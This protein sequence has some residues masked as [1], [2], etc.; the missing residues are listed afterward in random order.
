MKIL[1][2][3]EDIAVIVKPYGVSSQTS[4]GE[5]VPKLLEQELKKQPFVVHRLDRTTGGVMVYAL[6]SRSAAR[7]SRQITDNKFK[8]EYLAVISGTLEENS[9]T[10][11]DLLYYDR[12]KNKSY[13]VKKERKGVKKA[14]LSFEVLKAFTL[15]DTTYSLLK[16]SLETGRTH[17]IRVQFA[18]RGFP[19]CGDRRYGSKENFNNISLWAHT[20]SFIHPKTNKLITYTAEPN[21]EFFKL[22]TD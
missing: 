17:Q 11:T 6:N 4:E 13:V 21:E 1:Y 12:Q 18:S 5:N 2:N 22:N 20:L 16:I 3:D 7:L 10:M 9:G 19:L 8:K 15:N 14:V